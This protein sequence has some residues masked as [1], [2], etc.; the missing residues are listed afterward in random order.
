LGY[1]S[2]PVMTDLADQD[3]YWISRY[4][5]KTT[6]YTTDGKELDLIRFLRGQ[7]ARPFE[8]SVLVGGKQ[9]LPA[10]LLVQPVPL[11]VAEQ[12]RRRLREQASIRQV[13]ISK[14]TLQLADWTLLLTNVPEPLLSVVEAMLLI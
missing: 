2:L 10:R 4:R 12:R 3:V 1:F 14:E 5:A 11:A 8:I 13:P 9:H 7:T 6:L